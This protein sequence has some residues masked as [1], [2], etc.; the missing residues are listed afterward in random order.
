MAPCCDTT[1]LRQQGIL[2]YTPD[3]HLDNTDT[4]RPAS[5][6][7]QYSA[8]Q[9]MLLTGT[10]SGFIEQL[11]QLSRGCPCCSTPLVWVDVMAA[12]SELQS[13]QVFGPS[14]APASNPANAKHSN[15]RGFS[16]AVPTL[17]K[18]RQTHQN[19][20]L[21][22]KVGAPPRLHTTIVNT[23]TSILNT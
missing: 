18:E 1:Q 15:W 12:R 16:S 8:E 11:S 14:Q 4:M 17:Q 13:C 10:A 20:K 23:Q 3:T 2:R 6:P 22:R 7:L 19:E 5:Y 21:T 9:H